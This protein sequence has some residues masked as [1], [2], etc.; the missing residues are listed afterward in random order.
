[1]R[2]TAM[3]PAPAADA[4][5]RGI[6]AGAIVIALGA[7][8]LFQALRFP[9]VGSVLF[10]ALGVAFAAPYALDRRR[11]I[12]LMPA[13]ILIGIGAGLLLPDVLNAAPQASPIFFLTMAVAFAAVYLLEPALRWPVVPAGV[14]GTLA[15]MSAFFAAALPDPLRNAMSAP[16]ATPAVLLAVGIYLLVHD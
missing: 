12:Y 7:T 11:F 9:D 16:F 3:R 14:F 10:I 6:L 5:P 4:R 2:V 8:F 13:A 15:L 1:M